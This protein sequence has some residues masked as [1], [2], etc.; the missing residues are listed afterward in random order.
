MKEIRGQWLNLKQGWQG[1]EM[2]K[3][4]YYQN[5]KGEGWLLWPDELELLASTGLW[6]VTE[7]GQNSTDPYF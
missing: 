4:M 2:E 1:C 7:I 6:L 3:N 5:W